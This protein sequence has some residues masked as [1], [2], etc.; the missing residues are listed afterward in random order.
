MDF[1]R[2]L[3]PVELTYLLNKIL[4]ILPNEANPCSIPQIFLF[5]RCDFLQSSL[6]GKQLC[7]SVGLT[8]F[9][10]TWLLSRINELTCLV[11]AL[12]IFLE[13]IVGGEWGSTFQCSPEYD[14]YM[15]IFV[16]RFSMFM[17]QYIL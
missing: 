15:T 1:K 9:R 16:F 8:Y 10:L 12:A 4:W 13:E 14:F 2:A 17:L 11:P 3:T 6:S 7:K 5:I